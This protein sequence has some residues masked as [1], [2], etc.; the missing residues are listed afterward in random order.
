M[1]WAL[2]APVALWALLRALGIDN[3]FPL[4]ALMAFTP[5]AA[6]AA[7]LVVG[8]ALA[9]RNWAAASVGAVATLVLALAV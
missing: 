9:L 5:Y 4:A 6:I 7:F 2:V 1:I 8:V 3:G